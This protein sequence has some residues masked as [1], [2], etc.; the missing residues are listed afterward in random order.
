V[1]TPITI[2]FGSLI[3]IA[4][5]PALTDPGNAAAECSFAISTGSSGEP[6]CRRQALHLDQ[7]C[8]PNPRK[9]C[10]CETSVRVTTLGAALRS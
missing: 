3:S 10:P 2:P 6:Q 4:R 1:L 8:G 7:V 5:S 9:G